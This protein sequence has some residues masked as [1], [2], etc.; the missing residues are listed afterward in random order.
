MQE[1]LKLA[2]SNCIG[3]IV[4]KIKM[5]KIKMEISKI[6][7]MYLP[8]FHQIPE[9]DDFWGEGFTDWVTV[10]NAKPLFEGHQQPRT[11]LNNNYYDLSIKDNI[12]WQAELAKEHDVYGFGIYHY[13]FNNDK[14]LLTKPA[15]IIRDNEEIGINYFFTWDNVSWKRTWSNVEGNDWAPVID[16]SKGIGDAILIPY[17]IG[18]EKDWRNHYIYLRPF[19]KDNRYIRKDNKP[20][21]GILHYSEEIAQMCTYWN[22]LAKEDGFDGMYFVFFANKNKRIPTSANVFKY[23]PA[24]SGWSGDPMHIRIVRKIKEALS[25]D[26]RPE[27]VRDYDAVWKKIIKNAVKMSDSHIYHGALVSFDDTPRRGVKGRLIKNSTPDKFE[28]YFSKL[29]EIS[30]QQRKEFVFVT[31]WNEWGEGAVLEPDEENGDAYLKALKRA[32]A[33]CKFK[34]Y[35]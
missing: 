4:N 19:L 31:A 22:Q 17:I 10:K 24:F 21:F 9:N 12:A 5:R 26:S 29:L 32:Y 16:A 28:K 23:E 18:D 14:N 35:T 30:S 25:I 33:S 34:L 15:E 3:C 20:M 2:H 13:W 27:I 6:I 7:A 1:C 8:Q 11:P